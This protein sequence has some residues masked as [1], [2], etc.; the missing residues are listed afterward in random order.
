MLKLDYAILGITLVSACATT[1]VK[2][3][4]AKLRLMPFAKYREPSPTKN[5]KLIVV[6]D[7]GFYGSDCTVEISLDGE[8]V[9]DLQEKEKIEF[10]LEPK[11]YVLD[12][13][14]G[15]AACGGNLTGELEILLASKQTAIIRVKL[16]EPMLLKVNE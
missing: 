7:S 12:S 6:R 10:N 1:A 5:A 9:T 3:N 16:D 4:E 14:L 13:K 15:G 11:Q 2:P 8:K